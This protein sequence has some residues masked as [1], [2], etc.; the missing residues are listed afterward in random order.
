M[1]VVDKAETVAYHEAGHC[2]A[3]YEYR[4][5]INDEGCTIIPSPTTEGSAGIGDAIYA[6]PEAGLIAILAGPMSELRFMESWGEQSEELQERAVASAVER[7]CSFPGSD[8]ELLM[9]LA[10]D[11]IG[12]Q[13]DGTVAEET[14]VALAAVL[15]LKGLEQKFVAAWVKQYDVPLGDW[16]WPLNQAA[17]T[18]R[19]FV[20]HCWPA[21]DVLAR[22]LYRDKRLSGR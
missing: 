14:T 7:M 4:L 13:F 2:V 11:L 5:G 17:T 22:R 16:Y 19:L 8:V 3:A 20:T 1:A 9:D 15:C 6:R 18:A 12:H 10:S 21:I